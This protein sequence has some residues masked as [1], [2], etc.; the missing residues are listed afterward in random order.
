MQEK[1]TV[2]DA[3]AR[4]R[5]VE[6]GWDAEGGVPT[7]STEHG[8]VYETERWIVNDVEYD[9]IDDA[10]AAYIEMLGTLA[11]EVTGNEASFDDDDG[12]RDFIKRSWLATL[13]A[14]SEADG[15]EA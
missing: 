10:V 15:E 1:M 13:E 2:E 3:K 5:Y 11:T 14:E 12:F 4:T 7:F 6:M 9:D 8:Y